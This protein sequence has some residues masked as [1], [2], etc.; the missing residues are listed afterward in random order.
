MSSVGGP[1]LA[2]V[3]VGFGWYAWR[4][5][6][7]VDRPGGVGLV[8]LAALSAVVTL[9][10]A[11]VLGSGVS[12][13]ALH[14][15]TRIAVY[16][17]TVCWATFVVAYTGRAADGRAVLALVALFPAVGLAVSLARL[18]PML[19]VV[20][21]QSTVG[22]V[23]VLVSSVPAA[24]SWGI[25]AGTSLLLIWDGSRYASFER[26]RAVALSLVGFALVGLPLVTSAMEIGEAISVE[27]GAVV[28]Q[29]SLLAVL[30]VAVGVGRPYRSLPIA[31]AVGRDAVV[32]NLNDA[33]VVVDDDARVV[34]MNAAAEE[35]FERALGDVVRDPLAVLLDADALGAT[36]LPTASTT[37]VEGPS[38]KRRFDVSVSRVTRE[39][40][41][42][43]GYAVALRD[44]TDERIRRQRLEVLHR[45][46]RHN[47]R[48]DVTAVYGAA[49]AVQAAGEDDV[50]DRLRE[51]ADSLTA[52][53]EQARSVAESVRVDP[54]AEEPT[55]VAAVA[56]A[57][58]DR[59]REDGTDVTVDAGE[60]CEVERARELVAT[61]C[62]H[63]VSYAADEGDG[64]VAATV[65]R[66]GD[67][68]VLA[69]ERDER[70][71][72]EQD[73]IAVDAGRETRLEHA[74]ELDIWAVSWGADRLGGELVVDRERGA[75]AG[76]RI[77]AA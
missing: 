66:D 48:N 23:Y 2:V 52:V 3:A 61:V 64:R 57:V 69:V 65:E 44:V 15:L 14:P 59:E 73:L 32:S 45:V 29:A 55:D 72:R 34:D 7:S 11:A 54:T 31:E 40:G 70:F 12:T 38:G 71:V 74:D 19:S 18:T 47:V 26:T 5:R 63:L 39:G 56:A 24:V 51:T 62:E 77:P 68:V 50:A 27:T 49:D 13:P 6:G 58:A 28:T 76:V 46:L 21:P 20:A 67:H 16:G 41:A 9:A 17:G 25:L 60:R 4:L 75:R 36:G 33:V 1:V 53:S 42:A 35:L 43:A 8:G 10:E 30:A 37:V 22:A